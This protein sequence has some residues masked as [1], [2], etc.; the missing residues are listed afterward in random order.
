MGSKRVLFPIALALAAAALATPV[1]HAKTFKWSSASDI[2][3]LD[4]HS[5]NNALGNGVH[6]AIYDS[7]VY[8]NSKTFKPEAQLA[9]SWKNVSPTQVRFTLRSGVKFSDGSALTADDVV[10]SLTRAM[11]KTSN[12]AVYA[13]GIDKVVKIDENTVDILL[14]GPNPV[15]LNQLTELRIMSK[16]WADKNKSVEPKD[17]KTPEE[18]YAHRNAMGTGA[19]MVKEWLPDQRLVL[20]KNPHYW[21]KNDSNVTEVVYTPIKQEATRAA[22]LLSGEVDFVLDPS[23]QDLGRLRQSGNLKVVDG[24]E[25]RTIF[26]GM[27]QFRDELPGSSVKGKNPLKDQRVRMALY[28]AIDIASLTRV[29]M[30]GLSQPTGALVAPQVNGWSEGVHKRHPYDVE[31]AKKLLADAGYPGGFEVDFACPN[32][33]Y[34]NDEEICQA[35]TAMWARVGIK[36]KLR[37]LPLVTY[38]PMIQRFEAS[39]Y[40]LGWG[41]PTFDALYSLQSLTRSVGG[42]GD[43]NYNVGRYSNPK[44]DQLVDRVKTETD[45]PVRDR[46]LTEALQL[47]NDDV[48]HIP[49]HNQIIP[50][51]MKKNIEVVHRADN[52]LDWR[53]IKV[54]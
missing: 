41:V 10:Y 26:F 44:M 42:G 13:Q 45:I 16:A 47:Q 33:R 50:W 34:I 39:I 29:T 40:M 14:K 19:F 43:G 3:T 5:Q 12:Y 51:A 53:L 15:L 17:I 21:G 27:D 9:S 11:A 28:Q 4:I 31:A 38:F 7:L 32:N 46:L 48:S 30:R 18:S 54:N 36:A 25:N 24:I 6:A 8:Y 22:A 35:V 23:P 1:V 52:R 37:T 20:V 2:P 49:L